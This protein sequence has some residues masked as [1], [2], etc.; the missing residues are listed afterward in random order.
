[1]QGVSWKGWYIPALFAFGAPW[2]A[3]AEWGHIQLVCALMNMHTKAKG[4]RQ[5]SHVVLTKRQEAFAQHVARGETLAE[6]YRKAGYNPNPNRI[7]ADACVLSKMSK[8]RQRISAIQA[9]MDT[10][11][12]KAETATLIVTAQTV[13]MMLAEAFEDAKRWKQSGAQVSAA[14]GLAKVHGLLVDKTEDI[15][16]RATRDPSA[17][18]EIDVDH[19]V[20]EQVPLLLDAAKSPALRPD[21]G[22]SDDGADLFAGL[23]KE[24]LDG[25]QTGL[26]GGS[27]L[28]PQ[29]S[30]EPRYVPADITP[31]QSPND[32]N[33]LAP[34]SGPQGSSPESPAG[35][36]PQ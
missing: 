17:P 30:V 19:W 13:S 33:D 7:Y 32:T 26:N 29:G 2:G 35:E 22:A 18:L 14:M 9:E 5:R 23:E 12:L 3:I 1:M 25:A 34:I 6:A 4:Q 31:P 16:R 10:V 20:T 15:T 27:N 28:R 36:K 21:D 11:R 8:V 24:G